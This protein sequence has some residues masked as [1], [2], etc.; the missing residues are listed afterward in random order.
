[1]TQRIP[2][3][4]TPEGKSEKKKIGLS[5]KE[6]H[7]GSITHYCFFIQQTY[8]KCDRNKYE[9][10][11][12]NK[13]IFLFQNYTLYKGSVYRFSFFFLVGSVGKN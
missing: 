13:H 4:E 1:M 6:N 3:N 2:P 5:E 8:R 9:Q 10:R 11:Y 12:I 7:F